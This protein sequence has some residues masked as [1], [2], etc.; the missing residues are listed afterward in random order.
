MRFGPR[1]LILLALI[2]AIP[3]ASYFFVFKPQNKRI[4]QEEGEIR[5]KLQ[6]L[7][8]LRQETA[9]TDDLIKENDRIAERIAEAEARL[10][11]GKE[12]DNVIRQVS[13]LAV[14]GGMAPPAMKSSDPIQTVSYHEQPLEMET[15]GSFDGFR[16][17]MKELELQKRITRMPKM[18]LTREGGVEGDIKAEFVLSIYFLDERGTP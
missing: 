1:E 7:D 4:T 11:S 3:V 18:K 14:D 8:K 10:P 9:R 12:V 2:V 5:H 15:T 13:D 6:M 17:F 16:A